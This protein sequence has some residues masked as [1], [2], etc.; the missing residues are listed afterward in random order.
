[1]RNLFRVAGILALILTLL[2]LSDLTVSAQGPVSQDSPLAAITVGNPVPRI[3]AHAAQWIRFDYS[4]TPDQ[5]PRPRVAI[6]LLN[7]V[8]TGLSFEVWSPE[9]MQDNWRDNAPVGRGGQE[10]IAGCTQTLPDNSKVKCM[11]NDLFWVGGFG[12]PGVYYVR[13]INNGD[14]ATAPQLIVSGPG[15]GQCVNPSGAAT[16]SPSEGP[17]SIDGF[18][19][20]QCEFPPPAGTLTH[21]L[22][23]TILVTAMPIAV[24]SPSAVAAT[25]TPVPVASPSA[26]AATA[27]PVPVASPSVVA[28]TATPVPVASPSVVTATPTPVPVVSPSVVAATAT[29]VPVVSPSVVAAT[30]TPVPVASPSAVAATATPVP[31]ASPSVIAATATP[32]PVAS[33]SAVAATATPVPTVSPSPTTTPTTTVTRPALSGTAQNQAIVDITINDAGELTIGGFSMKALGLGP[34]DSQA[35]Q[36]AKSLDNAHVVLQGDLV[37]V[38]VHGTPLLKIQW[39]PASRQVVAELAAR[40]GYRL[41]PETL[42]RM[43]EWIASSNFD[44]TARYTNDLSKPLTLNLTKPIWVDVGPEGQLTVETIPLALTLD[45]IVFQTIKQSGIKNAILCWNKGTLTTK[46]DG[47]NLPPIILDPKGVRLLSQALGLRI[48]NSFD[49]FFN[50]QLGVDVNLP[51]G[52]HKAGITCGN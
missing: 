36:M 10:I 33:P 35:T 15:L 4:F 51:G 14:S 50:Y 25:A 40:Y 34:I 38:D 12:A 7:G 49:Q 24:A 11:T 37:T 31:V 52:T 5:L 39:T 41:S 17:G 16:P 2:I 30:A 42:A 45:P 29:P 21:V 43:E 18:A 27:T 46:L 44:I 23:P 19:Q 13:I 8:L 26:V 28:A 3:P 48:E 9:R 22:T 20:A 1:M 32:V 6:R 47:D